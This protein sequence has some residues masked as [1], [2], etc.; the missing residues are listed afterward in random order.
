MM[1]HLAEDK[2]KH[3]KELLYQLKLVHAETPLLGHVPRPPGV[4]RR[5]ASIGV[6][7]TIGDQAETAILPALDNYTNE[8]NDSV[9]ANMSS[10]NSEAAV[11][12]SISSSV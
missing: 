3:I 8:S 7:T 5:T 2:E 4:A 9:P 10:P 1:D 12:V 6:Q 11:S